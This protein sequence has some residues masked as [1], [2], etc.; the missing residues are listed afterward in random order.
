MEAVR[1]D[2]VAFFLDDLFATARFEREDLERLG[3]FQPTALSA[4]KDAGIAMRS[5]SLSRTESEARS[6]TS[7]RTSAITFEGRRARAA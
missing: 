1:F 3:R 2:A 4:R 6:A 7:A 5:P